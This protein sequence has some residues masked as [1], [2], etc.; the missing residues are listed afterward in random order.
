MTLNTLFKNF[1]AAT[2][3]RQDLPPKISARVKKKKKISQGS[4]QEA[5]GSSEGSEDIHHSLHPPQSWASWKRC[6]LYEFL[7]AKIDYREQFASL[8]EIRRH[9]AISLVKR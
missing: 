4:I 7:F 6:D 1:K 9:N 2:Q 3:P 8:I 5:M